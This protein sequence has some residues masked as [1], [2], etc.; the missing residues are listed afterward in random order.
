MLLFRFIKFLNFILL[1]SLYNTLRAIVPIEKLR[2][3]S[4]LI[5]HYGDHD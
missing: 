4:L 3:G 2:V 5:T 1:S